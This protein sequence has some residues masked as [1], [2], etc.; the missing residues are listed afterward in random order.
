M[1]IIVRRKI[2]YIFSGILVGLSILSIAVYGFNLGIDFKGGT[3][4]E[5][6]FKAENKVDVQLIKEAL[7]ETDLKSL[8]VQKTKDAEYL[9]KTEEISREKYENIREILKEKIGENEGLRFEKVGPT[10]G[11]DLKK[12]AIWSVSLAAVAI[13]IYIAFAFRNV[14]KPANSFKFGI[15]AIIALIH[16]ILIVAGLFSFLG[17]FQS[18]FVVDSLFI[19]ALLTILGFSVND[20]IVVFDRLREN[21]IK[22]AGESSFE[23]MSQKSIAETLTR[24]INTTLTTILALLA[25]LLFGGQTI[26]AFILALIAGFIIGTYSS[27]FV[28]TAVL[29]DWTNY[30][31][32]H[33]T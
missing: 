18:S 13:V 7:K 29:T 24:S 3:L 6:K 15:C 27:I 23:E 31:L 9:I 26:F 11:A 22:L 17:H 33:K 10:I 2:W 12:K 30:S 21:L 4:F 32:R 5:L 20:T 25:I 8:Q 1:N 19:T 16:D 28:A 14:P